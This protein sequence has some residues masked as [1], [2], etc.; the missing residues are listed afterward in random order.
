MI[1]KVV[2]P[3]TS[4]QHSA[5]IFCLHESLVILYQNRTHLRGVWCSLPNIGGS[6]FR[7][8][9]A[10]LPWHVKTIQMVPLLKALKLI[11]G[12]FIQFCDAGLRCWPSEFSDLVL[13]SLHPPLLHPVTV[14]TRDQAFHNI[15][16]FSFLQPYLYFL[17]CLC[18]LSLMP[19]PKSRQWVQ[20]LFVIL[21]YLVKKFRTEYM[22]TPHHSPPTDG[23]LQ[24]ERQWGSKKCDPRPRLGVVS[25]EFRCK[26]V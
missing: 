21:K 5:N 4:I 3:N 17:S 11:K 25:G 15:T 16:L 9:A 8:A 24:N 12:S 7:T 22:D 23:W 10:A 13:A 20:R 18:L 19:S 6:K 26:T 1:I 2:T 14:T